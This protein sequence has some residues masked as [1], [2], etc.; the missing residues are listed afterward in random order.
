M[1]IIGQGADFLPLRFASWKRFKPI[2]TL[3]SKWEGLGTN[4]GMFG[5]ESW[6]L[7]LSATL[8]DCLIAN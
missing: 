4:R 7:R 8:S 6:L 2:Y 5:Y 3:G 1:A